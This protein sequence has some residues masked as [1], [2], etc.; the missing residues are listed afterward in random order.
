MYFFMFNGKI[1]SRALNNKL[2]NKKN[3]ADIINLYIL[4]KGCVKL[5]P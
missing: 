2:S 3:N 4:N 1:L 5:W